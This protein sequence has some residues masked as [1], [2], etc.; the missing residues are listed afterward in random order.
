MFSVC[1][2]RHLPNLKGLATYVANAV[3]SCNSPEK[4]AENDEFE[5][6]M[7]NKSC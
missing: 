6:H 5:C 7:D 4:L 1:C 3:M 2:M